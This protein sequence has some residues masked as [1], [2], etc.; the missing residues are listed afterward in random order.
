MTFGIVNGQ[1]FIY[2]NDISECPALPTNTITTAMHSRRGE[3]DMPE[4]MDL[5]I[6]L[7]LPELCD[8]ILKFLSTS[9]IWRLHFR[10]VCRSLWNENQFINHVNL[11]QKISL[12]HVH[13]LE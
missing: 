13:C 3:N 6:C 4:D 7:Y 12:V 1:W 2:S 10:L 9:S 11:L 5:L 8:L